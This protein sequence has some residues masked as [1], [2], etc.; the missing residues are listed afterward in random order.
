MS[1][2]RGYPLLH[3]CKDPVPPTHLP[4]S[5]LLRTYEVG[6]PVPVRSEIHFRG[7]VKL[8][9]RRQGPYTEDVLKEDTE[10]RNNG[11]YQNQEVY[12]ED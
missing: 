8:P 6:L 11:T 3:T 2:R 10:T 9:K 7:E 12:I 5:I 4:C 1:P